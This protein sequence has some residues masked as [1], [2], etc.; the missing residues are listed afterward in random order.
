MLVSV[1]LMPSISRRRRSRLAL[2]LDQHDGA[3][4]GL[5]GAGRDTLTCYGTRCDHG[6]TSFMR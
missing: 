3:Y 2:H 5:P 4:L 6:K 1:E